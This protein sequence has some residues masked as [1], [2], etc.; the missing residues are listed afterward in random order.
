MS[1]T[2]V[3]ALGSGPAEDRLLRL[4]PANA[5]IVAGIEDPHHGVQSGGNQSGRLLFTTNNNNADLK[6][7]IA[8]VGVADKQEVD[9]LVEVAM[10]SP[11]GDLA[12]HL[13]LA[14]GSFEGARILNQAETNGAAGREYRGVRIV[15]LKPFQSKEKGMIDTRWLTVIDDNTAVFGTPVMV[16]RA[17]DRYLSSSATDGVLLKRMMTLR[18]DVNCWSILAM[19]GAV[20]AR[21]L[22]AGVVVS[23]DALLRG[24]SN[25]TVAVHYGSKDRVDFSIGTNNPEAA[26]AFAA[27]MDGRSP[28]MPIADTLPA[29]LAAVSVEQN[30]VRGSVRVKDEEFSSWLTAVYARLSTD[31]AL[32]GENVARAG[33]AR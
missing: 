19:P 3:R 8:L 4:V 6:D 33:A 13:L 5:A 26:T 30:E 17:L 7:W 31:R 9:G 16:M 1:L 23:N 10:P 25:V 18:A 14:R 32:S 28:L 24:V 29:R 11:R 2:C 21:H 22:P 20:L 27:A 12:D 15:E